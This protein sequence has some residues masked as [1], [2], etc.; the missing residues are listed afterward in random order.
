MTGNH[1]AQVPVEVLT[2]AACCALRNYAFRV[3]IAIAAQ[4][5]GNNNGDLAMTR[6]T[7]RSFGVSSQEHLVKSLARLLECG[8]IQKTRQG[9]K[10]PLGP[11]LYAVTWQPIDDLRGKIES[12]ATTA[13]TN[14]WARWPTSQ[15]LNK[16]SGP[17][18]GYVGSGG[19]A[20][21]ASIGP[22]RG[23]DPPPDRV[24]RRSTF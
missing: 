12:G 8:L 5:R 11:S 18:A 19:G 7:A 6:A 4:Y 10:K 23:P 1:F 24:C 9:G 3:L 2:S 13:P 17:P 16:S 22:D 20:V 15:A 14:A 21:S